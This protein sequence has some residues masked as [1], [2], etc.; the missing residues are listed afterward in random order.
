MAKEET[1]Q[2]API[3]RTSRTVRAPQKKSSR[4][5]NP[6]IRYFQETADELRKV[7]WPTQEETIRLSAIV[8]VATIFFA[9]FLFAFDLLF[10]EIIAFLL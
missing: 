10:Q 8:L 1:K 4:S 5:G 6:I 7:T 2:N 9:V 3:R